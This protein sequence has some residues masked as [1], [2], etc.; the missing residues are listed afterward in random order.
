MTLS[1]EVLKGEGRTRH[2]APICLPP[3]DIYAKFREGG[4]CP[5]CRMPFDKGKK[6]KL[7]DQ[8]G[9]ERCYSCLFKSE[10]CPICALQAPPKKLQHSHSRPSLSPPPVAAIPGNAPGRSKLI[11]NG[12]F[13]SYFK[14]GGMD[15]GLPPER[16][17]P[18]RSVSPRRHHNP[19]APNTPLLSPLYASSFTTSPLTLGYGTPTP[20]LA[21]PPAAVIG[22]EAAYPR[23]VPAP[24]APKSAARPYKSHSHHTCKAVSG[25]TTVGH[26]SPNENDVPPTGHDCCIL[27][28]T[29][30]THHR[31]DLGIYHSM[32]HQSGP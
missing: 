1:D 4:I 28:N 13:S 10:T 26:V 17:S 31:F 2:E 19:H 6:R 5:N 25:V 20:T 12:T 14:G 23:L 8:C 7:I 16:P 22:R 32:W 18:S 15:P 24:A 3:T 29:L 21:Y 11:T 27:Y 30:N 9:H